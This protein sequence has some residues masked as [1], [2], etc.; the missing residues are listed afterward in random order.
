MALG[1]GLSTPG[2]RAPNPRVILS[3][4]GNLASNPRVTLSDPRVFASNPRDFLSNPGV[5]AKNPRK[6]PKYP[7]SF[8]AFPLHSLPRPRIFHSN[9]QPL[10]TFH[11]NPAKKTSLYCRRT[12]KTRSPTP[13]QNKRA[14]ITVNNSAIGR[15]GRVKLCQTSCQM[16]RVT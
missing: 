9:P 12:C 10:A 16:R 11:E 8:L 14:G 4:P 3:N 5:L 1:N 15:K 13:K 2:S 6:V 7:G